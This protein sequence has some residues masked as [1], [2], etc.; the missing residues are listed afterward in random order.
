MSDFTDD[1]IYGR[2][3]SKVGKRRKKV[4]PRKCK[5]NGCTNLVSGWHQEDF[6]HKHKAE[7]Q[8]GGQAA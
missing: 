5:Y 8:K 6:C 4:R 1:L 2:T 3:L 7:N